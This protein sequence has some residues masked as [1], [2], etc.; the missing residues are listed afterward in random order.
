VHNL[1]TRASAKDLAEWAG[2]KRVTLATVIT[3]IVGATALTGTLGE[4]AM[5]AVR[6]THFARSRALIAR[7]RGR[8]IK[9]MGDS[10]MV[11]FR[12]VDAALDYVM[13]LS[14]DTG[15]SDVRI[16][17]GIHIGSVQVEGADVF[18]GT[19][20]YAARVI[21]AAQGAEIWLS[22]RAKT[23]IDGLGAARHRNIRWEA[24]EDAELKGF[25]GKHRLW[26]VRS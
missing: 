25:N 19:V 22:D 2:G 21:G 10:F 12:S 23:D 5:T 18:G 15:H 3:D 13:A 14:A 20:N 4:E 8:E 7:F 11:V 6:R 24:H 26:S 17:A 16:R 1:K 9:T